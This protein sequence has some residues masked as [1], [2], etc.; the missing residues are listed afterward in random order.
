[1]NDDLE[2]ELDFRALFCALPV[3]LLLL[4]ADAPAYTIVT[5]TQSYLDTAG[6]RAEDLFGQRFFDAF[7]D[8]PDSDYSGTEALRASLA[9][10]QLQGVADHM[11]TTRYD[12]RTATGFE[13]RYWIPV[14]SPLFDGQGRLVYILHRI[15]DAT[16]LVQMVGTSGEIDDAATALRDR[17]SSLQTE[18]LRHSSNLQRA[19]R[20][21]ASS[22]QLL[23]ESERH[24]RALVA[25]I[26][27]MV[28]RATAAPPWRL[29]FASEGMERL[30]G[31]SADEF[32]EQ[33]R[34]FQSLV[35]EDDLE[36]MSGELAEQAA[37]GLP[38]I[39]EYRIRCR[40]GSV[41]WV[42]GRARMADD[43]PGIF[44]G[45]VM[46]IDE[47]KR[48][49]RALT[50]SEENFRHT[51]DSVPSLLWTTGADGRLEFISEAAARILGV[52]PRELVE[53]GWMH[54]L[55]PDDQ[56][57]GV[58]EW[59]QAVRR[60]EPYESHFRIRLASGEYHTFQNQARPR[61][62]EHG[63]VVRWYG[64]SYDI[65]ELVRARARAEQAARAR[66][67]FLSAMSHE[68]R[69]PLNAVLGFAGLLADTD[70]SHVQRDFVH[71]IRASGDHLLRVINDILDFSKL[72]SGSLALT[73]APCQPRALVASAL[74]LV[75]H[76]AAQRKLQLRG[77]VDPGVPPALLADEGRLRQILVNLLGNGVKF[78]TT[79][80][81]D[82]S[83]HAAPLHDD[84]YEFEFRVRDTGIGIPAGRRDRLFQ[85]FSQ[86]DDSI[87]RRFGGT[88]LG[89]A[90]SKR[91][92]EAHGGALDVESTPG[93]G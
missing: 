77:H 4:R 93:E 50:E 89:L 62:D 33:G 82:V 43:A 35:H 55:H 92:V 63:H 9:R 42:E 65:E 47:R 46:D 44:E 81:V 60:G 31:W 67:A 36:R 18:L 39:S 5:A 11:P 29:N 58:E 49:E 2:P 32:I 51:V 70:L 17:L 14:N 54:V 83:V 19:N 15:E 6:R 23:R 71:S 74:Q 16:Q 69:T 85:D 68:I 7:P 90:I 13:K 78:T 25:N 12:V 80:K 34:V 27:G 26:P 20:R 72:E 28:F 64:V 52:P 48:A 66:S 22:E 38:L 30:T 57:P 45:V 59:R 76:Q 21:L 88:G 41:R 91:L 87:A 8:N 1:M 61:R 53:D 3:R 56:E 37:A 86:V 73:L 24:F 79:G 10:V 84:E 40:D 75:S